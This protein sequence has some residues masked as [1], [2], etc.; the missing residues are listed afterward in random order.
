ME[1]F[2][3]AD[4]A[5][6]RQVAEAQAASAAANERGREKVREGK[7]LLTA[8]PWVAEPK[9]SRPKT[10]LVAS[11]TYPSPRHISKDTSPKAYA[12]QPWGVGLRRR[13]LHAHPARVLGCCKQR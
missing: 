4:V 5:A 1:R 12:I 6:V 3:A 10:G 8:G 13:P 9:L 7:A 2:A 11:P